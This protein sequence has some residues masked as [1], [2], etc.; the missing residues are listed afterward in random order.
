VQ[1]VLSVA[2]SLYKES[3]ASSGALRANIVDV[4]Q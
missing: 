1:K 3:V 2:G 4:A